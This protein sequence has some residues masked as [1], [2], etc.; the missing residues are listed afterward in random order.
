VLVT[1]VIWLSSQMERTGMMRDLVE[2]VRRRVSTR[3]AMAALPAVIGLLPMPGGALFSAP[4]VDSCDADRSRPALLKA[5]INYWFRHIWE[6]WWPLYPGVLVALDIIR[7]EVWQFVIVQFAY[8]LFA[9]FWGYPFLLRKVAPAAKDG[10]RGGGA[11]P[12]PSIVGPVSPIL[13][14]VGVYVLL[15]LFVPRAAELNRYLPLILALVCAMVFLQCRRRLDGRAWR[16][17]VSSRK[18]L[19]MISLVGLVRIYGA[20]IEGRL[21]DGTPLVDRMQAELSAWGIPVLAM[22]MVLPFIAGLTTGLTIGFVG[23]GFPIVLSLVGGATP[24][25]A[26]LGGV[27]LAYVCG[28]AG[29]ILS[30]VHVCL[31][32]TNEHFKTRLHHSLV[33]LVPCA[34]LMVLTGL[35]FHFALRWWFG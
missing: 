15:R 26:F 16:A 5:K 32:V 19:M 22:I 17:I 30:P 34:L 21:A 23:A 3:T 8:S 20:F 2:A 33:G 35:G 25:D 6:Y 24:M 12:A 28:F 7:V 1:Q 27:S 13:V 29:M 31:V 4:L 11:N 9:V 10:R 18:T 14:I